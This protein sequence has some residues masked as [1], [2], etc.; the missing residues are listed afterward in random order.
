[1]RTV[2][3]CNKYNIELCTYGRPQW[4]DKLRKSSVV[5]SIINSADCYDL[6]VVGTNGESTLSNPS[7]EEEIFIRQ[8]SAQCEFDDIM[9]ELITEIKES[10][11]EERRYLFIEDH[12]EWLEEYLQNNYDDEIALFV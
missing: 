3:F 8:R 5:T 4:L 10:G 12:E 6:Y 1:M 9:T 2:E 11:C 7:F